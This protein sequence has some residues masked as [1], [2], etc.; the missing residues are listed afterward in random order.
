MALYTMMFM[1]MAPFGALLA[2]AAAERW[3][4]PATLAAGGATALAGALAFASRI[5][6]LRAEARAMIVAL[7]TPEPPPA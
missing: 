1:G 4:A 6:R 3:G 7:D 5:P 2:G